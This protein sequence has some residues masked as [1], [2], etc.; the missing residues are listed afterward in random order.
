MNL[1]DILGK[2]EQKTQ[3]YFRDDNRFAFIKRS[4]E[5]SC[6]LEKKKGEMKRAWNHFFSNQIYFPGYKSISADMVILG[7]SRDVILDPFNKIPIGELSN[8]KPKAK[9]IIGLK[10]WI[11]RMA[12]NQRHIYRSQRK[13][14]IKE[15]FVN[16]CLMGILVI[17]VLAWLAAFAKGLYP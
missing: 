9:D 16:W 7:C 3:L 4:L 13:S 2:K 5:Y 12:E 17:M 6:L 8:E 1:T 14:T 15:D 10:K 11:K